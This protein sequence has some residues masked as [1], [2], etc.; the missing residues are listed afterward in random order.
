MADAALAGRFE[1]W[2]LVDRVEWLAD[3]LDAFVDNGLP[4]GLAD[5]ALAECA[6]QLREVADEIHAAEQAVDAFATP[7]CGERSPAR[8]SLCDRPDRHRGEHSWEA[9][10]AKAMLREYEVLATVELPK[11]ERRVTALTTTAYAL[12]AEL[13]EW[14]SK[15][16]WRRRPKPDR[17]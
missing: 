1:D 15:P 2:G 7:L 17:G 11:A 14:K 12:A 5:L 13:Q 4:P 6:A 9:A 8:G 10:R 16:L 3:S